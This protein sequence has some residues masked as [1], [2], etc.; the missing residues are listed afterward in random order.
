[1]K[2]QYRFVEPKVKEKQLVITL[3]SGLGRALTQQESKTI[4][5]ISECEFETSGVLLDLFKE[6]SGREA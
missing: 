6:L 5:W 4:K 3:E 2:K 1:M